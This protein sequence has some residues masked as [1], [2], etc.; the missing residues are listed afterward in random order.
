[1]RCAGDMSD[2]SR[3]SRRSVGDGGGHVWFHRRSDVTRRATCL[4][5]VQP[6]SE[7]HA[8]QFLGSSALMSTRDSWQCLRCVNLTKAMLIIAYA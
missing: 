1:M 8:C 2:Q 7:L 4:R 5:V 3:P 6:P